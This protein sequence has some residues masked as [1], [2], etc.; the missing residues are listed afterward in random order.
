MNTTHHWLTRKLSPLLGR[1]RA[2]LAG[3]GQCRHLRLRETCPLVGGKVR[4]PFEGFP[5]QILLGPEEKRLHL[6]P[7]TLLHDEKGDAGPRRF[8]IVDPGNYFSRISG[9]LRL[10][11]GERLILGRA[12]AG[13]QAIFA[14]PP[15]VE[16]HHLLLIH[17][18]DA[19]VFC[20][21]T[22]SPTC[23]SPLLDDAKSNRLGKLQR[24]REIF[25]GPVEPLGQQEAMALIEQV[26]E[27]TAEDAFRPRDDRGLPG[28]LLQLPEAI[29]PILVADLHARVDNLLTVLSQN[30]FLDGLE[31]GSACLIIIGDAVHSELDGEMEAMETSMLIMDLIFRLKRRFPTRVFFLRGNHDAFCEDIAKDGIPQG[32]LWAKALVETRGKAYLQAME[33]YYQL[34]PYVACSQRFVTC[35]AAPPKVKISPEM[36]VDLHRYPGLILDLITNR[37]QRPNRPQGYTRGD[38]RRFRKSLGLDPEVPFIVGHTPIDRIDTLWLDVGGF[39]HHHILYSANPE[40]VGVFTRIGDT[41]VPLRYQVEPLRHLLNETLGQLERAAMTTPT[42]DGT[43]SHPL[44]WPVSPNLSRLL[45]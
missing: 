23:I 6:Y 25:G 26:I 4:V 22:P 45:T 27:I 11:F 39:R 33:R 7:E 17:D 3:I 18:G 21:L 20:N 2:L 16:E 41:M 12:D 24:L 34:M 19:I 32:L 35:H 43:S 42:D 15:T 8:L 44:D 29:T 14:Y 13:Q 31:D 30:A 36:L 40:Q 5:I 9:F 37:M 28:G 10:S 38:V 1:L